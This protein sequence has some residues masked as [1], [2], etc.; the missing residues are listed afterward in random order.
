MKTVKSIEENN[1]FNQYSSEKKVKELTPETKDSY[2]KIENSCQSY[3]VNDN[4]KQRPK[5]QLSVEEIEKE[6]KKQL[7]GSFPDTTLDKKDEKPK[8][9]LR[10]DEKRFFQRLLNDSTSCARRR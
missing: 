3:V 1:T 9:G 2:G 5:G 6:I 4:N 10:D 7:W 8:Y